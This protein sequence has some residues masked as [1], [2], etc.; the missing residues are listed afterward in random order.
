[1][2]LCTFIKPDDGG[3]FVQVVVD[4][5]Q[6]E[7]KEAYAPQICL[8]GSK[9]VIQVPSTWWVTAYGKMYGNYSNS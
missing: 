9:V 8:E 1:M 2:T 6:I 7:N 5:A 4:T 3:V